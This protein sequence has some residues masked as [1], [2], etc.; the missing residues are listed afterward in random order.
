VPLL[1]NASAALQTSG[2]KFTLFRRKVPEK[3]DFAVLMAAY[4]L[5]NCKY[6]ARHR[7]ESSR[8]L[9]VQPPF[10][11]AFFTLRESR[12][13]LDSQTLSTFRESG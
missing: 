12:K 2:D 7:V 11:Y 6:T 10:S 5:T 3:K 1:A 8:G 4:T 13:R 9:E